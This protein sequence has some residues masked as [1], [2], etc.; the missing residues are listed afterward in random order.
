MIE[1]TN[2]AIKKKMA[3]AYSVFAIGMFM[4]GMGCMLHIRIGGVYPY[5]T[6]TGLLLWITGTI[7]IVSALIKRWWNHG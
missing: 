1:K 2:K 7:M 3:I 6:L 5:I 4:F